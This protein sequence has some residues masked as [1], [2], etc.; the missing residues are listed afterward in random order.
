M[1]GRSA[2]PALLVSL[3]T[4]VG[5][6][7][8]EPATDASTVGDGPSTAAE[9][10]PADASGEA[11]PVGGYTTQPARIYVDEAADDWSAV[12]VRHDDAD[13]GGAVGIDRLWTAHGADHLFLRLTLSRAVNLQE[14]NDLTLF[15]DADNDPATGRDTLGLGAELVW[16]FGEREGRVGNTEIEHADIGLTSLPTV[17]SDEFEIAL[18]RGATPDGSPLF[19]G[20]S[21]RIAL[22]GSGDRLP[23]ADGGLGYVL[24]GTDTP[25]E[26]PSI[27]APDDAAVRLA[28]YNAVNNFDREL[29]SLFIDAKQPSYRRLLGALEADVI[30]FQEVYDQSASQVEEV[31]EGAL[32]LADEWNWE[33]KGRDLVLG[34]R[35]PI[36]DTH[37]IPGYEDYESG[38]F[39]LD[40][41][42]ALGRRM[43]VLNMHPPCCNYAANDDQPSSD[44][45]RQRVA[46]GVAAFI[47]TVKNGKGPF[48]VP[49]ETPIVILGD[50]NFVGSPRQRETLLTGNIA[51]NDEFG[52]SQA[53][54]WDRTA[55]LDTRPRQ[56]GAPMH[57]TW[58]DAG[59]SFPP[60]R[61]DYAFVTDSVIDVVH[62][63]VL[64]T[65]A[66]SDDA[67]RRHGLQSGDTNTA[68]DHLPVVIDVQAQ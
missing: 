6:G 47:R 8:T 30:A 35:F 41:E 60:G 1:A 18:N 29:N 45:Q 61:L 36:L 57:T 54:D 2:L 25:V 51:N 59:S 50:M 31:A 40:T 20:D 7:G 22:T 26:A 24:S 34:S 67:L 48:G 52:A 5:C 15:L 10:P 62:E 55:L 21:L 27:E 17:Q 49:A 66:L 64:H 44:V 32:G 68:S 28:S 9:A 58:I 56:A 37:T 43:I 53:P 39:L 65:P 33:K 12:P 13:D 11:A 16:T 38:A 3:I 4:I 42:A 14:G 19:A 63:F 23:D 46:D